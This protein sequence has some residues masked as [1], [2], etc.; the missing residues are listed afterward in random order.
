MLH[1]LTLAE[2]GRWQACPNPTVG[3]VLV[4]EG[5][6][7]AEGWHSAYGQAHAEVECLRDAQAKGINPAECSL[8]VTLEPCNHH[9]KTPPCTESIIAA[10]ISHVVIGI[11]DPNPKAAGGIEKLQACGIRVEYGVC[12]QACRDS[13]SDFLVWNNTL[14]PFVILKMAATLDGRIATR[15]GH[16]QWIS[17]EESRAQVHRLR[18]GIAHCGGAVL[19]GG[20]TFR[21]DNP[22]LTARSD[23]A[24]NRYLLAC[25]LTSRLPVPTTDSYLVQQRPK[26]TIFFASPAAAASP[27]AHALRDLGVRVWS[28][29]PKDKKFRDMPPNN[30]GQSPDLEALLCRIR[31]E[32]HCPYILCEGGGMLALSLLENKLVDMF[33]LHTAPAIL[34]DNEARPLFN[35]RSPLNM[36]EALRLRITETHMCGPDLHLTLRPSN[37]VLS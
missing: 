1:A 13:I 20:G 33:M 18:A 8:V 27:T 24:S 9:G 21:A 2:K 12:E 5:H 23:N 10:G 28:V 36:D 16:S 7:V 30:Y 25:I 6:I 32:L 29:P 3:A 14:R 31:Q 15:S 34:G 19:I 17:S 26:E 35:G 11:R 4:K 22:K 37:A